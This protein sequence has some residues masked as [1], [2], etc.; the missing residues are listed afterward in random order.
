MCFRPVFSEPTIVLGAVDGLFGVG[1]AISE[2]VENV[3]FVRCDNERGD[4]NACLFG[5]VAH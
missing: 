2:A 1:T 4:G 3:V 5:E